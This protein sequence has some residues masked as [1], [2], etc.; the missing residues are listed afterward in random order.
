MDKGTF[1]TWLTQAKQHAK[2]ANLAAIDWDD[3]KWYAFFNNGL[4]PYDAVTQL[5]I[6]IDNFY[7]KETSHGE[8]S[9]V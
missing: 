1:D 6:S 4:H 3:P 5:E 2:Q 9:L 7:N 8:K